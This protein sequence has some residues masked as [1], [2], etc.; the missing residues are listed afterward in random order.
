MSII[1]GAFWGFLIQQQLTPE[2][3]RGTVPANEAWYTKWLRVLVACGLVIP[4]LVLALII[5]KSNVSNAY[6]FL[7]FGSTLPTVL[8]GISFFFLADYVNKRLGL[9]QLD[10]N[11]SSST[12]QVSFNF[13][14]PDQAQQEYHESESIA[15]NYSLQKSTSSE[16]KEYDS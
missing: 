15:S 6:V 7:V 16:K 10:T 12:S 5:E 2:I 4:E 14:S 8:I 3:L 9:L 13:L 1:W 11:P